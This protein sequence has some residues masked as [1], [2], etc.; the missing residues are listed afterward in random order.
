MN[1]LL[2]ARWQ[3]AISLGFHILFAA[4]GIALPL[5]MAIAEWLW[6]RSGNLVYLNLAKRWSRGAAI[7][8]AVGAVSGT[9]LSFELGLLWPGF[10]RVAGPV[11]GI[12]FGLEA[13]AFFTEAIFLGIYIYGWDRIGLWTHWWTG[14]VVAFSGALSGILVVSVNAWMNT[15]AG[16]NLSAN[17]TPTDID[18]AAAL[19]NPAMA[20]EVIHMTSAAYLATGFMVAGVHAFYLRRDL[21]NRFHRKALEISLAVAV[22]A[23]LLQPISGDYSAR[24]VAST[25]PV[26]LAAMEGQFRTERGAPLRIGGIPDAEAEQTRFA[27]EVPKMLSILAYGDANS[28]V[29]GLEGFS[30]DTWP[31]VAIVHISFQVMVGC[32]SVLV[33]VA[34]WA[35]AVRLRTRSIFTSAPLLSTLIACGP[36][37]MVAVVAGWI[38]TEV[39]RQPW[40]IVGLMRTSEAVTSARHLWAWLIG[41]STLYLLLG[42]IVVVMMRMQFQ[43]GNAGTPIVDHE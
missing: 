13:F 27:I 17:G 40:I 38:V 28:Q 5:L 4:V 9:V 8:F 34:L 18:P 6:L 30:R 24:R 23:A 14:L 15:P 20:S 29:R 19:L 42:V 21:T 43:E 41:Y 31:P 26:K 16:F 32:G 33:L 22:L 7:L 12:G 3:M 10:M 25:Q 35:C 2:A 11:I 1:N 39:G 36:L 37:G